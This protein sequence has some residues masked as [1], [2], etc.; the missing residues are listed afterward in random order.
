LQNRI[1]GSMLTNAPDQSP[2]SNGLLSLTT[3]SSVA[4]KGRAGFRLALSAGTTIAI[5]ASLSFA[6]I[7]VAPEFH[8]QA[9]QN[10]P[11]APSHRLPME[12]SVRI[13]SLSPTPSLRAVPVDTSARL[14]FCDSCLWNRPSAAIEVRAAGDSVE[15]VAADGS[16]ST[17]GGADISGGWRFELPSGASASA[18]G[19]TISAA[20]GRLQVTLRM[21]MEEYVAGVLAAE[22]KGF[23]SSESLKAMAVAIRTY[24]TRFRGRHRVESYDFCDSTHCQALH[25]SLSGADG[26]FLDA[27]RATAGEILMY[28]GKPATTYYH[29]DCGGTTEAAGIAWRDVNTPYLTQQPDPY[30]M[31]TAHEGWKTEISEGDLAQAL[32]AAGIIPPPGWHSIEVVTR[33][34]SGRARKLRLVGATN[35]LIAAQA[36]RLAVARSLD[37]DQVR[38][39]LFDVRAEGGHYI[40]S[41][42]GSG[43]GVGLCQTGAAEM[44]VE[45]K[46]Y[47]EILSFYYPGTTLQSSTRRPAVV[48]GN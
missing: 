37:G 3:E 22:A 28:D 19:A 41:G 34:P 1:E 6:P 18:S 21:T 48:S 47:D 40:F 44:G 7:A 4:P 30:C 39:D 9:T 5:L 32:T 42:V 8:F 33:T 43:H 38:S 31:R 45:G 26:R 23:T 20:D 46:R 17:L 14:R 36:L 29:Q 11:T 35:L 15:F 27:T 12:V 16:N 2:S 25:L 10:P 24:A 13:W